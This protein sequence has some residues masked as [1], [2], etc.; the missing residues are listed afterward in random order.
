M[1]TE[2]RTFETQ[3]Y[4]LVN[5]NSLP[6]EVKRLIVENVLLKLNTVSD[7]EINAELKREEENNGLSEDIWENWMGKY[8]IN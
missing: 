7:A 8:T 3:L 2:I 6:T 1:N 5:G 4:D